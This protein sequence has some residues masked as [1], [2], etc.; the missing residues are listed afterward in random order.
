[1]QTS[2]LTYPWVIF[3]H[4][5]TWHDGGVAMMLPDGKICALAAERVGDRYKHSWNSKLAYDY[6][7]N[8]CSMDN[9]LTGNRIDYFKNIGEDSLEKA[10]HHLNHAALTFF[11]S[12]YKSSAILVV[13]GQGPENGYLASTTLWHGSERGIE[14]IE[15]P[16]AEKA[17]F[18]SMSLGHFYTAIGALAGM[19]NLFEEGKTMGLAAYGKHSDFYDYFRNFIFSYSNGSYF[20]DPDFIL[21]ILGNTLGPKFYGWGAPSKRAQSIWKQIMNL[22]SS[23]LR[24]EG[25]PI[26]IDD[27]NIAFA[28]QAILEEIMIGLTR[29]IKKLTGET[30]IC[31]AGGVALN[32]V[33]NAK[34]AESGIFDSVYV[35]PAPSD[36]GQALG[37]LF[38]Y[39]HEIEPGIS[40]TLHDNP[41]FG[42]L[43]S[44]KEIRDAVNSEKRVKILEYGDEKVVAL[45]AEWIS[46]G[47]IVG[48]FQG[49]SEIGPRALGHR[50]I[51]ADPR[52]P[53]TRERINKIKGREWFRPVAPI[54]KA[55]RTRDYF[56][57]SLKSPF[58]SFAVNVKSEALQLIPSAAHVD[59]TARLQT[60]S[61]QQEP[62]L[63]KL[64]DSFEKVAGVPVLINTS[65]NGK[66]E[67]IVETPS[68]ALSTFCAMDLDGLV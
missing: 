26:S 21:A 40:L 19:Q 17:N 30:N 7:L 32:C 24:K 47:K 41:F 43:Y 18:A 29:R 61:E 16:H 36:D 55:D 31:L 6:L 63:Y 12:G 2:I 27:M 59:Q 8:R 46:Q 13:D 3:G 42:P 68:N 25:E 53:Q 4:D 67:P 57:T 66:N 11:S 58:M 15:M 1:M 51:L 22:R 35:C 52:N 20:I 23:P 39:L 28:G 56:S 14:L 50:S 9:S 48:W 5:T 62:L 49:G 38:H 37:K 33:A 44:S 34:I 54:V 65:F 10:R 60:L 64:L 45:A